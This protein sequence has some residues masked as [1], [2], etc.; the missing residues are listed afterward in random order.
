MGISCVLVAVWAKSLLLALST[1]GEDA[2]VGLTS[3]RFS[4]WFASR[5]S[6]PLPASLALFRLVATGWK[7]VIIIL[8]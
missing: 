8:A 3:S 5:S 2:G 1:F 7:L 4:E 6:S